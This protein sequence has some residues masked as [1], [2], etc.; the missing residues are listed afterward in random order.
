MS[1]NFTTFL[2]YGSFDVDTTAKGAAT[3]KSDDMTRT[4]LSLKY[5]F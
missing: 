4:R 5:T 2:R 3:S 1:K